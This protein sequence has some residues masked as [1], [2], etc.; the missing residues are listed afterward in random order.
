MLVDFPGLH[1]P[2]QVWGFYIKI[3]EL[4]AQCPPSLPEGQHSFLPGEGWQLALLLPAREDRPTAVWAFTS[5]LDTMTTAPAVWPLITQ[6]TPATLQPRR[7]QVEALQKHLISAPVFIASQSCWA[8]RKEFK[9]SS[10][11]TTKQK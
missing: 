10:L 5:Q 8:Q 2:R 6:L 1:K 9:K 3:A 7:S 4:Y 11:L